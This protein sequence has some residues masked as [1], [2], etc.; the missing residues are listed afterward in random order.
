MRF[1]INAETHPG[2][3]EIQT[4]T[5]SAQVDMEAV[6]TEKTQLVGIATGRGTV[7]L[8]TKERER[9]WGSKSK[10]GERPATLFCQWWKR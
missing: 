2:A 7:Y 1:E 9:G 5:V 3:N 8:N 10:R 4:S 6:H